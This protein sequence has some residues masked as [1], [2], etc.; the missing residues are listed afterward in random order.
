MFENFSY[1]KYSVTKF[2]PF[3]ILLSIEK[4][5]LNISLEW[6]IRINYENLRYLGVT[7]CVLCQDGDRSLTRDARS[8]LRFWH[9]NYTF[10]IKYFITIFLLSIN[11]VSKMSSRTVPAASN[12][13][14]SFSG[15]V[16]DPLENSPKE[17]LN[18][19]RR[20]RPKVDA[21][22]FDSALSHT[23]RSDASE[24]KRRK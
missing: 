16:F 17:E 10:L 23:R 11:F 18:R 4:N 24:K 1:L 19:Y 22:I 2:R 20:K 5:Y 7:L 13:I 3:K 6:T 14:C 8:L 12:G 9:R 15:H 21:S